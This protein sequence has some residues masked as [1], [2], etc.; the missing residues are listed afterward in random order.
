MMTTRLPQ[1]NHTRPSRARRTRPALMLPC[2]NPAI[3]AIGGLNGSLSRRCRHPGSVYTLTRSAAGVG[4]GAAA[5]ARASHHVECGRSRSRLYKELAASDDGDDGIARAH[6]V[7][8]R[9]ASTKRRARSIRSGAGA[10]R[11]LAVAV[12]AVLSAYHSDG[13]CERLDS[14]LSISTGAIAK[15]EDDAPSMRSDKVAHGRPACGSPHDD[16]V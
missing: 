4:A 6:R 10:A 13:R 16:I 12:C 7:S 2:A 1:I 3:L 11:R 5:H 8:S 14:V 9:T 15:K